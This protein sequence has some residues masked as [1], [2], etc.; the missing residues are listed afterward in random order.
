[1]NVYANLDLWG[2]QYR[3]NG[4]STKIYRSL[5]TISSN[6]RSWLC[7]DAGVHDEG[8][9]DVIEVWL[10]NVIVQKCLILVLYYF[11]EFNLPS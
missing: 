8:V 3:H 1:M 5:V 4:R 7:L 10:W 6:D 9:K 2:S 11:Y